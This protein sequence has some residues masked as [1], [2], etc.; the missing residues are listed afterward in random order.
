MKENLKI[1]IKEK[2]D[3]GVLRLTMNSLDQTNALSESM[4][5]ILM[6]ELTGASSD[7]SIKVIVLAA[8]GNV[9]CSGHDLKEITAARE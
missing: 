9:F 6:D 8:N 3:D 4:M 1:L 5:S 2:S 7:Q